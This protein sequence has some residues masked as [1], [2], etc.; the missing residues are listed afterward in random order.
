[1]NPYAQR[2]LVGTLTL[3][4][5]GFMTIVGEE[6][7]TSRAVVPTKNDRPTVGFG[8]TFHADGSPVKMGD[9]V[10]P[11]RALVIAKAHI[12]KEEKLF[13]ESL[14]GARLHQVEF[15]VYMDW[16]YQYGTG[17]WNTSSMR[18]EILAGNYALAC[19][20][21]LRYKYSGGF[22]C[23]IPG[24]KRCSGVWKRQ[25]KRHETCMSVQ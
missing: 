25:L 11:V 8:S 1:M 6:A 20:A 10:D 5:A 15:D 9:T 7:Y 19:Q 24:N 14:G 2:I 21:L 17:A 4:F 12:D 22:D 3:S 23:S 13:R 16:V 18:K